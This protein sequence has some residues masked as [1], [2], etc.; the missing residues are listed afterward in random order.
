VVVPLA[1][2]VALLQRA[3]SDRGWAAVRQEDLLPHLLPG[4]L[5]M[6]CALADVHRQE[7]GRWPGDTDGALDGA[8][9]WLLPGL[10]PAAERGDWRA[11][12]RLLPPAVRQRADT[13]L[14]WLRRSPW[15]L[16]CAGR[17]AARRHAARL[18]RGAAAGPPEAVLSTPLWCAWRAE[19]AGALGTDTGPL[20]GRELAPPAPVAV[21]TTADAPGAGPAE[22]L[23]Y[24]CFGSEPPAV[25]RPVLLRASD[26]LLVLYQ[27]HS[28][29]PAD[30]DAGPGD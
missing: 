22:S 15:G 25:H 16:R 4:G 27:E 2:D 23:V 21:L 6:A 7:H 5:E 17:S 9:P 18:A 30:R 24:V 20:A 10:L 14:T 13:T 29:L 3:L 1:E 28:P 12:L 19:V 26:R 11:W 8:V